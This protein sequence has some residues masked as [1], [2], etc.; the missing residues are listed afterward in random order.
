MFRAGVLIEYY[1]FSFVT[2]SEIRL[3]VVLVECG[4]NCVRG[5]NIDGPVVLWGMSTGLASQLISRMKLLSRP[6][7][8]YLGTHKLLVPFFVYRM[9]YRFL[10]YCFISDSCV[11]WVLNFDNVAPSGKLHDKVT[12]FHFNWDTT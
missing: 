1:Q 7:C 4:N 9:I 10:W 5:S 6:I 8:C 12:G 3:T 2:V 11:Y